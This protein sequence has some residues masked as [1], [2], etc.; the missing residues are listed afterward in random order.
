MLRVLRSLRVIVGL[1]GKTSFQVTL[2]RAGPPVSLARN[3]L[4][5]GLA[6]TV[7]LE[8]LHPRNKVSRVCFSLF[9]FAGRKV[10]TGPIDYA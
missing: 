3:T 6:D 10:K 5:F 9:V 2:S 1:F 8:G 4:H 7:T